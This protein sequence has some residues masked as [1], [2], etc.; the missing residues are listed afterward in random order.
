MNPKEPE[1]D[2]VQCRV[3]RPEERPYRYAWLAAAGVVLL[4]LLLLLLIRG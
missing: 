1:H 2:C 4:A 3:H